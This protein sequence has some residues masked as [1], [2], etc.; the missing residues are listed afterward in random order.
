MESVCMI[1]YFIVCF[2][3]YLGDKYLILNFMVFVWKRQ[4]E[5]RK[6]KN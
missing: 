6:K 4:E 1:I 2:C 3:E 5:E